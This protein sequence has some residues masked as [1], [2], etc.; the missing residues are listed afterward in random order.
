MEKIA[1][2]WL[3]IANAMVGGTSAFAQE[4]DKGK[5]EYQSSCAACHGM[6]G[7][8]DGPVSAE[9]KSRPSDLTLLA[10]KNNGVFPIDA[11]NEVIDGTRQ[12][13]AHGN[14][15]MPVWGL[16]YVFDAKMAATFLNL[17]YEPRAAIFDYLNRIQEK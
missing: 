12:T 13:R 16:R 8:G 4:I 3:I 17:P 14:R 6:D 10:K 15:E 11:L 7:K 9:L 2:A 5:V 1:F